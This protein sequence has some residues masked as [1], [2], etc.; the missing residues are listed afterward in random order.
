[1]VH[2]SDR[3]KAFSLASFSSDRRK[4]CKDIVGVLFDTGCLQHFRHL[5]S[6]IGDHAFAFAID[7]MRR[8]EIG[9]DLDNLRIG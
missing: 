1:V 4:I 7:T 5:S 3:P 8:F 2:L 6:A 9:P